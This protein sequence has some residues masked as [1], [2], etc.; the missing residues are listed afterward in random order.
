MFGRQLVTA[1]VD[2]AADLAMGVAGRAAA[3]ALVGAGDVFESAALP[4]T[5][6]RVAE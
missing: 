3:L 5:Q 2:L 4:A 6:D 1:G